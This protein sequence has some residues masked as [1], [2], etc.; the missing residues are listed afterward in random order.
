M[1][2]WFDF[3]EFLPSHSQKF[4]FSIGMP[5]THAMVGF[6]LPFSIFIFT[7]SRYVYPMWLGFTIASVWCLLVCGSRL[8]LGMHT[9]LDILAGLLLSA[10][11][12]FTCVSVI[13]LIDEMHF[14]SPIAPLISFSIVCLMAIY[15]PK[16]DRWSPARG[17]TCVMIAFGFGTLI[18]TWLNYQ[19][20][21][22]NLFFNKIKFFYA[23]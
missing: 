14:K 2:S 7:Q 12:L 13:D 18:G 9:V 11:I 20:G 17:D 1:F 8:Y 16:P 5:S 10:A 6:A 23:I 4:L 19:L 21:I 22:N 15:Y 3:F